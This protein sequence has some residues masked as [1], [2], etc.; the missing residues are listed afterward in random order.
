ISGQQ[1]DLRLLPETLEYGLGRA[2]LE[3]VQFRDIAPPEHQHEPHPI[4]GAV[5]ARGNRAKL[6]VHILACFA[7][8]Y[9]YFL[10]WSFL[11]DHE[12]DR[13]DSGTSWTL[14]VAGIVVAALLGVITLAALNGIRILTVALIRGGPLVLSS[15]GVADLLFNP[16]LG[17]IR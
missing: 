6:L 15:E 8:L 17:L 11:V 7:G 9:A 14:W 16:K 1:F 3:A 12:P 2:D 13:N 5:R 4:R 10:L